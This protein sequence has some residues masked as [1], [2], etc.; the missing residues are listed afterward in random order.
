MA[1]SDLYRR[2]YHERA[3]F[4]ATTTGTYGIYAQAATSPGGSKG[5]LCGLYIDPADYQIT[6][7]T[8]KLR[9]RALIRTNGTA[10]GCDVK[11]GL[12]TDANT[13]SG[14]SAT[15][16]T[17]ATGALVTGSNATQ[18]APALD[19]SYELTQGDFTC[20]AAGIYIPTLEIVTPGMAAAAG[21]AVIITV[22]VH[23]A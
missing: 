11:V 10:P 19:T 7:M 16:V 23:N 15:A 20:P 9:V 6:N 2:L 13:L 3:L 5:A 18:T 22:D 12:Y 4:N 14:A 8:L 21:M 1:L 17:T